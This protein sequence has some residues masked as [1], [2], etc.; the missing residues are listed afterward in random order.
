[1]GVCFKGNEEIVDLLLKKG[2]NPNIKNLNGGT[3]LMFA[4]M[5]GHE[6]IFRKIVSAGGDLRARNNMGLNAID[7]AAQQGNQSMADLIYELSLEH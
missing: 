4:A 7:L 6:N 3:A 2:A 1:M 5:F